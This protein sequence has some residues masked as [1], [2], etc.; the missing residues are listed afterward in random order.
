[1]NII[2][3]IIFLAGVI[4]GGVLAWII[5]KKSCSQICK[6]QSKDLLSAQMQKKTANKQKILNL[7]QTKTKITNNDIEKSL[8]VSHATAER[9]LNE[10]EKEGKV[11]QIGK[12]GRSVY[13]KRQ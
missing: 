7:L 11:K 6:P 4:L 9:Y 10:L 1:M 2:T 3:L 5:T 8:K 13:Y 12:I